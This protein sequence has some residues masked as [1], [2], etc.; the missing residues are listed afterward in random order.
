MEANADVPISINDSDEAFDNCCIPCSRNGANKEATKFCQDCGS[1]ICSQCVNGHSK[2]P[3]LQSHHITDGP[4]CSSGQELLT[5]RCSIH[6]G[7]ILD[8]YCKDHDEVCCEACVTIKHRS[9]ENVNDLNE[10]AKNI[11][12]EE[13][14]DTNECLNKVISQ[15]VLEKDKRSIIMRIKELA[16]A[17]REEV[18]T[19]HDKLVNVAQAD[20]K[21]LETVLSVSE[22][23]SNQLN[24]KGLNEAQMFVKIKNKN[25]TT[26]VADFKNKKIKILDKSNEIADCIVLPGSPSSLCKTENVEVAVTLRT[27]K[28]VQF[29]SCGD[30]LSLGASFNTEQRCTGLYFDTKHDELYVSCD[31][32]SRKSKICVYKRSG[33][34]L[35]IFETDEDGKSLFSYPKNIIMEPITDMVYIADER[36]GV[37]ALNRDGKRVWTFNDPKLRD[38]N[39]ICQLPGNHM[40]VTGRTS[41]NLVQIGD[42]GKEVGELLNATEGLINPYTVVCDK[43]KSRIM[44]GCES[45]EI[46][47]YALRRK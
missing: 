2:F 21:E 42:D 14:S 41:K 1:Y 33:D 15:I 26:V 11:D 45:N 8:R 18:R 34:I 6:H 7:R 28:K 10:S 3:S 17:S 9:C 4:E 24:T 5:E 38:L 12:A 36:N 20:V 25:D 40:L 30:T 27:E 47:V 16:E 46:S 13:H 32:W 35:R 44:I 19:K 39:G 43:R 23:S 22:E 31:S 37:I 29:V